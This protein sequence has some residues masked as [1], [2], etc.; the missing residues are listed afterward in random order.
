VIRVITTHRNLHK[1][2]KSRDMGRGWYWLL[3]STGG[4]EVKGFLSELEGLLRWIAIEN[5][6]E[7]ENAKSQ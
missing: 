5:K 2:F 4:V 6:V 1:S 3:W 7:V